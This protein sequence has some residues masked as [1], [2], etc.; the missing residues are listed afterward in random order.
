MIKDKINNWIK[1]SLGQEDLAL[2][3]PKILEHGDYSVIV[4]DK[5]ANQDF[6]ILKKN[7][8]E[9]IESVDFAPPRFINL[10]LSKEFFKNSLKEIIEKGENFGKSEHAKGFK[11]MVEHTD[12]NYFKRLHIGHYMPMAI[13]STLAN[14]FRWNGADVK[15]A[16]YYSDVGLQAAKAVWAMKQEIKEDPY[17]YG[18]KAYD[19]DESA[20]KEIIEI[21][22]KIYEHSDSEVDALYKAGSEESVKGFNEVYKKFGINFDLYFYESEAAKVGSELVRKNIGK[23]FENSDGAVIFRAEDHD[24]KLHTRVFINSEGIPTYEAK[25][26]GLAQI[27][28]EKYPHDLSVVVTANEQKDYFRVLLAALELVSPELHKKTKHISHGTLRLATGKMSSRTGNVI[29]AEDLIEEV[30]SRTKGDERVAIGAIKYM[31]L[32]QAIGNDIVFDLEKSVSTEGDSG[33]YLQY[34]HAR[35]C[36]VLEKSKFSPPA[37]GEMSQT[38]GVRIIE[39]LLYRFPE[40]VERAGKEYAPNYITTYL[41][42]LASAF[43][44]FY[45][46][47]QIVGNNY[48][49]AITQAFKNVMKN[50]LDILG[51]PAPERM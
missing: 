37:K 28:S 9:F 43:N 39:R 34:A 23:V 40:I 7:K 15:E 46:Q 48:R 51:I 24:P 38:E 6:E 29:L 13:G 45:A 36:S 21:N 14:V 22:K 20:K 27:K 31:I 11:V 16:C 33:V 26:L 8:S 1:E 47:E 32:R 35:A 5:T 49:V 50:G 42:E 2:V 12:P 41:T 10:H 18:T 19:T 30:K 4:S 25:D 17:V 3:H 44:N